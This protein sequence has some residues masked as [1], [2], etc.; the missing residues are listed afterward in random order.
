MFIKK[1]AIVVPFYNEEDNLIFFIKEWEKFVAIRKSYQKLLFFYF[2]NDGST[3]KSVTKIRQNIKKLNFKII[4]K[5]NS[6]HGD[7]CKFAYEMIVKNNKNFDYLL[8]IDSDNQ[9]DPIYLT[10]FVNLLKLKNY[11]FI[12]GFR[13]FREDGYIRIL[14][15]RILS[16]T[17]YLKKLTYIKDLNTPYRLMKISNLKNI[18]I[19]IKKKK[20]YKNIKL[21]NCVLSYEINS[22]YNIKWV[23]INFRE[24][25][26]G[27]SKFNFMSMLKMYLNFLL[28]V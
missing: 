23:N 4:N 5:K 27:K 12:F 25:K 15:S 19:N 20:K 10:K 28:K 11:D 2:I 1:I 3:D 7:S 9:C 26:F 24:R 16:L 13:K 8:Q 6:G 14:N 18:L 17:F 22:K 21:F